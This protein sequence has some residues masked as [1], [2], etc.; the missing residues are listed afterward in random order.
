[1]SAA[2]ATEALAAFLRVRREYVARVREVGVPAQL[3]NAP[4]LSALIDVLD[5]FVAADSEGGAR[6]MA[7]VAAAF[8]SAGL[9]ADLPS[10]TDPRRIDIPI[11][12]GARLLIGC[13]VKQ[14]P[15]TEATADTL[16]SDVVAV[17]AERGLLA[18]L[19]PGVL[20]RVDRAGVI[21]RAEENDQVVLRIADGVREVV[22][23]AIAT[24]TATLA[25][26]GTTFPSALA[27]ALQEVRA[28]DD[29]VATWAAIAGRW[30]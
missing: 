19:R 30:A 7:L 23:E 13:E 11:K 21:R 20:V 29:T 24:G 1:M 15:T 8:R 22:H 5:G 25:E 27:L 3:G 28:G 16:I 14:V 17:G 18:V 26:F 2:E 10:P 12:R 4:R 9:D 6:G